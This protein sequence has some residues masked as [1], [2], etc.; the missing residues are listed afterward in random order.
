[1]LFEGI[2]LLL[3]NLYKHVEGRNFLQTDKYY[4]AYSIDEQLSFGTTGPKDH[5]GFVTYK[6][7]TILGLEF[8]HSWKNQN[9]SSA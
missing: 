6:C 7:L 9:S 1:M 4:P 2:T 8:D 5:C 3:T